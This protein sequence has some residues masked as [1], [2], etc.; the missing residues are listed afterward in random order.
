MNLYLQFNKR[1]NWKMIFCSGKVR[2]SYSFEKMYCGELAKDL[3][4][5]LDKHD[6][7]LFMIKDIMKSY[8]NISS[9]VSVIMCTSFRSFLDQ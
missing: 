8:A 5:T 7:K 9:K 2:I 3:K 4:T 1:M 6:I